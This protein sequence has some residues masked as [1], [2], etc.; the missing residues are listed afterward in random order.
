MAGEVE[1]LERA[2]EA[3]VRLAQ[4]RERVGFGRGHGPIL[5]APRGVD[6][7]RAGSAE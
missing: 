6:L 1:R 2:V 3:V 4:G 5:P 7:R